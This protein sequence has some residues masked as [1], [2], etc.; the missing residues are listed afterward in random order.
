MILAAIVETPVS[1]HNLIR[2]V[3]DNEIYFRKMQGKMSQVM[4]IKAME[5]DYKQDAK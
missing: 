3:T 1:C 4:Y 5:T 2:D